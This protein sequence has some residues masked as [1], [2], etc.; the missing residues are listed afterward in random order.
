MPNLHD[1][2]A[3]DGTDPSLVKEVHIAEERKNSWRVEEEFVGAIR[4]TEKIRFTDF[5]KG[6]HYMEVTE[7]VT[8][9]LQSGAVVKLPLLFR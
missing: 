4:G 5:Q 6:L 3:G 7:A 8:R 1:A 2:A 9:S